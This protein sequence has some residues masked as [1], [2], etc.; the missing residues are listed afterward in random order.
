MVTRNRTSLVFL[1]S[2]TAV[3]L[4]LPAA[5]I[6]MASGHWVKAFILVAWEAG[7]VHPVDNSPLGALSGSAKLA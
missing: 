2:L 7:I 3:T 1:L 5:I 4:C 6:L